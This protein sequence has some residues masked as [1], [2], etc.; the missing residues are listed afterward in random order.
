[1]NK[2]SDNTEKEHS[3]YPFAI[4]FFTEMKAL[5]V[6]EV[7]V[8]PGSRNTP[9]VLAA[10]VSGLSVRVFIDERVA[11]FYAL[12]SAKVTGA[13]VILICTSGTALANYLPSVVEANHSGT[14]IVICS[15]DRPPELRQ[16]GAGQTIDQVRL[17][18]TNVRWFYNLPVPSEVDATLAQSIAIR[19][20]DRSVAGK[21]PVHLNWPLREPLLPQGDLVPQDPQLEAFP[22]SNL[23]EAGNLRI[24]ELGETHERG[25]ISLG[26]NDFDEES[27][28]QIL[29]FSEKVGWPI[30]ADPA[31]QLRGM[32]SSGNT[33][34]TTGEVLCGS[35]Q[36]VSSLDDVEV[37]IQVGLAPTSKAYRKWLQK[38]PPKKYVL[39]APAIDWVDP[40]NTITETYQGDCFYD[41]EKDEECFRSSSPWLETWIDA[42]NIA[43]SIIKEHLKDD[44]NELSAVAAV[45]EAVNDDSRIMLSNSMIIRD[46]E[47]AFHNDGTIFRTLSNRGA[48]GIDGIISTSLGASNASDGKVVCLIGDVAAAHDFGAVLAASRMKSD[49]TIVLL[50]NK[51]GGI[52]SFL[53]IRDELDRKQ[54]EKYF[55]TSPMVPFADVFGSLGLEVSIPQTRDDLRLE[56]SKTM[57]R[58]GL[59][60]VYYESDAEATVETFRLIR[61]QFN[62]EIVEEG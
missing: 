5:G 47:L 58:P 61:E 6:K 59:S 13:P 31:S 9:L 40:S 29:W 18:G 19:T 49:M 23:C 39:V 43:V 30:L 33:M 21:G 51:G 4:R 17:Y 56:V 2:R 7:A 46:A 36:F 26:P 52:F 62:Q 55:L 38:N 16:W 34:I 27:L 24:I 54:F 8:S 20:W 57:G 15:A 53:P 25:L 37:V 14:P 41:F 44:G 50:D 28:Q 1:M 42:N 11:G 60:I 22:S 35:D 3:A 48:N 45:M 12:G 10:D 32:E